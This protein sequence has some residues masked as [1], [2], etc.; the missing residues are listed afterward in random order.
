MAPGITLDF[1]P[2]SNIVTAEIVAAH[3]GTAGGPYWEA[4]PQYQLL[5]LQSY[6]VANH[7]RKPQIF[8]YSV[9]EMAS[10]NENMGKVATDLQALLQT[11]Q[12]GIQLPF[13]PLSNEGQLLHAQVQYL[14]FKNGEGVRFLTQLSQGMVPVNNNELIYTFQGLTSDGKHYVAAILPVTNPEL[15]AGSGVG[16]QQATPVSNFQDYLSGLIAQLNG[17]RSDQFTPD[18]P[19]TGCH[20]PFDRS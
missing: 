17:Q 2:V 3:P 7:L 20:D 6:P 1:S 14:A 9:G 19:K 16:G 10:A 4:A 5:T 12:T 8:I 13:L 18:L 15:P 11:K